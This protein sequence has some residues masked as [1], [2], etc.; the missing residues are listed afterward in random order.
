VL[1]AIVSPKCGD[2]GCLA[3]QDRAAGVTSVTQSRRPSRRRAYPRSSCG[4][5]IR[6]ASAKDCVSNV[7]HTTR[8]MERMSGQLESHHFFRI[9]DEIRALDGRLG[10]VEQAYSLYAVVRW[11]DG[12][13]E[14]IDQFDRRV[15]VVRRAEA[16]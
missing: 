5:S 8:A 7:R 14:E 1:M 16:G 13:S 3:P 10:R 6:D 9:G 15:T 12:H 2:E 4:P 11:D